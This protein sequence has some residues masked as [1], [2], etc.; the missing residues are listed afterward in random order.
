MPLDVSL[1]AGDMCELIDRADV[2]VLVLDQLRQ[3]V[4]AMVKE[5]CP[6]VRHVIIMNE[7]QRQEGDLYFDDLLRGQTD[8]YS[9]SPDPDSLCTI[10]FTSGT[11]GKSKG[12]MLTHRNMAENATAWI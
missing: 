1:P 11:T 2:T 8:G 6:K 12:V 5:K 4:A 7:K 10:M 3:D 9:F